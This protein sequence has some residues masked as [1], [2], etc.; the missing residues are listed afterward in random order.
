MSNLKKICAIVD[1]YSSSNLYAPALKSYGYD[2]IAVQ[3]Q[4]VPTD[5][6]AKSFKVDDFI[7]TLKFTGDLDQIVSEL[8]LRNV[9]LV[10]AGM[11]M[12][13]ELADALGEKMGSHIFND[14][15][16]SHLRRH[17]FDMIEAVRKH[18]LKAAIQTKASDIN[19]LLAWA[20]QKGMW[21]LVLKP[22]DSGGADRV[23]LCNNEQ[24]LVDAFNSSLGSL[25]R[26][27]RIIKEVVAQ[28]FMRG[29]EFIV[30]TVSYQGHHM[31]VNIWKYNRIVVNGAQFVYDTK[32]L[33]PCEGE[34]Q[35]QLIDYT[36]EAL[37]AVGLKNGPSHNEVMMTDGGPM[38]VEINA[39]FGGSMGPILNRE[40]LGRGQ[41]DVML[42]VIFSPD[43]FLKYWKHAYNIKKPG[44]A[45]YHISK[46]DDHVINGEMIPKI[47]ALPSCYSV[48]LVGPPGSKLSK[49]VDM[50]TMPGMVELV[51]SDR[52]QIHRDYV[53]I[54][55]MEESGNFYI[56]RE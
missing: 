8:R 7:E 55:T 3:S 40:C 33:L 48:G 26:Q 30:D 56:T 51:H 21:P 22:A 34:T 39:R 24:E 23:H 29:T 32:E 19:D 46:D 9:Q 36:R 4:A 42:D 43:Q 6:I 15:R 31:I 35:T 18:G 50:F 14:P 16:T 17:K 27:G 12:G 11:E 10:V 41:L 53:Q 38:L 1:P 37:D 25:G 52:D 20:K 47:K 44:L 49:T 54:R 28:E 45:V 13:L 2:C 5:L